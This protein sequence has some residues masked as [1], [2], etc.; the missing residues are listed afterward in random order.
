MA[1][2]AVPRPQILPPPSERTNLWGW[3]RRNLFS[4]WYNSLLT[5][6]A[7]AL[8]YIILRPVITWTLTQ[9][10]W[11]A[12]VVN[13]RLFLTGTYPVDQLWRAW[14]ALHFL[15]AIG[16]LTWGIW[17]RGRRWAGALILTVPVLLAVFVASSLN[18]RLQLVALSIV[19]LVFFILGRLGGRRL[20]RTVIGAWI[21][22]FPLVLLIIGGITP[23]GG[24]FQ[25][26]P[27][28]F[29]GG[30]MLT[31]LLS[32]VGILVSFPLGM[33]L[34]LGRRSTLPVIRW[35]SVAYIEVIRGVPLITILFMASTM[36]PLF[37]PGGTN[38]DR[39]LRAMVGITLF[40]AAYL[41]ENIR[42]G[43]QAIPRGQ[44]EAAQALGLN[45]AL[46]MGLIIMPQAL[47]LVI[48]VLVGQFISLFKDTT[49]VAT[50]GL[51]DLLGIARSV[52][53]QPQ[54]IGYQHEVL[55]FI[56]FVYWI[57]SYLM[58]RIS[59]RLETALGVGVR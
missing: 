57:I 54:F 46:T 18:S 17:V 45:G 16:G 25:V 12:I 2:E 41:A 9:A 33:L 11:G 27:T 4:T 5:L 42:G 21:L 37:L 29:W 34:A 43:L 44:Y 8:I 55:V 1:E 3:A 49:L 48:P 58:A 15:A 26:V 30:L 19:A 39:V 35:V 52:L 38:I 23:N 50:I 7:L 31:F 47:R 40:S 28:N 53:A 10:R 32:V 20:I 6:A 36:V 24:P 22:Y 14:L 51:L 59:R 56:T 13:L